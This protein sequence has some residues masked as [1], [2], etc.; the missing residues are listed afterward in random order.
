MFEF[1]VWKIQYVQNKCAYASSVLAK[2]HLLLVNI[3]LVMLV[4]LVIF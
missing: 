2:A 1:L 4:I 3:F